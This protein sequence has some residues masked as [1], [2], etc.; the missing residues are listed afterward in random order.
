MRDNTQS[1]TTKIGEIFQIEEPDKIG[2]ILL[3]AYDLEG[4]LSPGGMGVIIN[5]YVLVLTSLILISFSGTNLFLA[6]SRMRKSTSLAKEANLQTQMFVTLI[7]QVFVCS[8]PKTSFR[9]QSPS[10]W[11]TSQL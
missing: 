5:H 11:F 1:L 6:I 2:Y 9:P 10:F 3:R 7:I 4:K 8:L